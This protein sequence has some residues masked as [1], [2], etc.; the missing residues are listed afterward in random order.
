MTVKGKKFQKSI[1]TKPT[2]SPA[3]EEG[4]I[5]NDSADNKQK[6]FT[7]GAE[8]E[9]L[10]NNQTQT[11]SNKTIDSAN[12]T[13]TVDADTATVS[14][15]EVDNLKSGVLETDLN[16]AVDDTKLASAQAIKTYVSEQVA[17]KDEAS[18][19]SY[20]N[21]TSGMTAT[22]V[23]TAVDEVE[24]RLDTAESTL[25]TVSTGLADHL[26]DTTDAHDASAIS[27][28]PTG[29]LTSTNVQSALNELQVDV[30]SKASASDLTNH[31]NATAS[32]HAST[33]ISYDNTTS[34]MTAINAQAAIDEVE[35]R[36]ETVEASVTTNATNLTNHINDAVGAHAAT[37][38]S[39]S[40]SGNLAATDVQDALEELQ[41]DIDTRATSSDLT[42]HTSATSGVHGVTGDVVGTTDTQTLTSKTIQGASIESPSRIDPKKDTK[43]NLE[44]YA[45]TANDGEMVFATDTKE[46]FIVK[47]AA[48]SPVGSG[49]GGGLDVF[50][51]EDFTSTD[52]SDFS[53]GNDAGLSG[54]TLQGTLT[55]ETVSPISGD[56]SLKYTQAAGSLNDYFLSPSISLDPKQAGN[57][58][59]A[60][61]YF[62]HTGN[63]GDIKLLIR[64][65]VTGTVSSDLDLFTD[66]TNPTR[67]STRVQ[68]SQG[69]TSI[70]WG[71]Q[72][73][74]ENVGAVLILDSIELSLNPVN[75]QALQKDNSTTVSVRNNGSIT[76]NDW[77]QTTEGVSTLVRA[78][79]GVINV[80]LDTSIYT[81][82]PSINSGMGDSASFAANITFRNVTA[83]GFDIYTYDS[84]GTSRDLDFE[85]TVTKK[86][87]DYQQIEESVVIAQDNTDSSCRLSL[88]NGYGSTNSVIRRY[89]NFTSSGSAFTYTDSATEGGS[90]TV[91][92]SGLYFITRKDFRGSGLSNVG[93]SVNSTELTTAIENI[94]PDDALA[95]DYSSSS[96]LTVTV[97]AFKYLNKGDIIRAHDN[98]NNSTSTDSAVLDIAKL[99]FKS[100]SAI[101]VQQIAIIKDV[102]PQGTNGGTAN[103]GSF[104]ARDL[105]TVEGDASIVS[106]GSNQITLGKGRYYVSGKVPGVNV[107]LFTS[108][109][110]N[111]ADSTDVI[112][113]SSEISE[114]G[115]ENNTIS[116]MFEGYLE[117]TSQSTYE[118]QMQVSTSNATI[119]LGQACN[120]SPKSEVYT[121]VTIIKI[122]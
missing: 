63:K 74:V 102:K 92:E 9:I 77:E 83:T 43:A 58:T 93:I 59:F 48:L 2:T 66:P 114:L 15:I 37:A 85:F 11:V 106:L 60:T 53:T 73:V 104:F 25:S 46:F 61:L 30:D 32:A 110:I 68:I 107:G 19:I 1:I 39:V 4:E 109:F 101:P 34:G 79:T 50:Y 26:A 118:V 96:G 40:P 82:A 49:S 64:D 122:R 8:R 5:R 71:A 113:G 72:V 13:V 62:T 89:S 42:T 57:S 121:T 65:N 88:G 87:P 111:T 6:V 81:V 69:A 35:G 117:V 18:E 51:T 103:T 112:E 44:I 84:S 90:V 97:G 86:K 80:T 56:V 3:T 17:T 7:E 55:N 94:T 67:F 95:I 91:N 22:N 100:L 28:V 54:G 115:T 21:T 78:N 14:N 70:N 23:Q 33:A 120:F 105:N 10:T 116:S 27:N 47:D 24:G 108:Q 12:N 99:G 16:N 38:I 41:T 45:T 98:G 29:N 119:G 20:N 31:I 36:V 75:Y 52:A 76:T